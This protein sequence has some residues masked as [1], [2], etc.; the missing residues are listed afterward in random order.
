M[1]TK[2]NKKKYKIKNKK[3]FFLLL[4]LLIIIGSLSFLG[5]NLYLDNT[6]KTLKANYNKYVITT[7]NTHLYNNKHKKIGT[8]SS[9]YSLEL[10][11]VNDLTI[12][13][14]YLKIKDSSYYI[15]FRDI[16]KTTKVE[17][18]TENN[19]YYLSLTSK[20]ETNS[21][22][23]LL[24]DNKKII[25]LNNGIKAN[26]NHIDDDY[27]YI[28]IFNDTLKLKKSKNIKVIENK[29][30]NSYVSVIHYETIN[31]TC[32]DNNCLTPESIK[33]HIKELQD[34]D[35]YFITKDDYINYL[36]GYINLKEKAVL[37]T[38]NTINEYTN[39]IK[40]DSKVEIFKIEDKDNIKFANTNKKSSKKDDHS[41]LN[42]YVA[43]KYTNI[44][45]YLKMASGVD[46][47]DDGGINNATDIPVVNY[48][49][50]FDSSKKE[51]CNEAICLE[52]KKFEEHLKWL[53]DNN[54]KTLTIKEFADWK[55]GLIEL[56]KKSVLLTIDDGA[57]GTGKHNGNILIPLLEKYKQHATLFLITG[58]WDLNNYQSPYLDVQSHS[59]NLHYEARCADGRGMV[60]CSDY[61][62]VKADLE[63]SIK[64]LNDTTSFCFPFYAS[65]SESLQALRDLNFRI[66]FVG[67]NTRAKRTQNNLRITRYPI[68]D[69][70][71]LNEFINIV[72]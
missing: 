8:I 50:F 20:V 59:N 62:T 72:K 49:F 68:L 47:I 22:V 16:K 69:D 53:Q 5:Y 39:K 17:N 37:L 19:S 7:K 54:Y 42:R 26:I 51:K 63:Q 48:H 61:K 66:A 4:L 30:D 34:N 60:V 36:K 9:N 15:Y 14:K 35:Y 21:K 44:D 24:K 2:K 71:T 1:K 67:G 12:K 13:N 27:Y 25:T 46:V 55:E 40:T 38:T 10:N 31:N 41:K 64:I 6:L 11:Q 18:N 23:D 3:I 56:P 29:N 58:W 33:I 65:D 57:M 43:K 70:I 28:N 45:D 32:N 52:A